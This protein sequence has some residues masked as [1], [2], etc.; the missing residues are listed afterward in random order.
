MRLIIWLDA[1][2]GMVAGIA[3]ATILVA[4]ADG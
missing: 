4:W 1:L 3:M 2:V